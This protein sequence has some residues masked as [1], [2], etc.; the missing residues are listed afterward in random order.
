MDSLTSGQLRTACS[1]C[2]L[3]E[4][5]WQHG[6]TPIDLEQLHGLVRHAENLP[7][8]SHLFQVG[9]KFTA[10]YAVRTGCVKSYTT[11]ASGEEQV[12]GFHMTGDLLG[13]DAIYPEQHRCNAAIVQTCSVCVLP[14]QELMNLAVRLPS[15]QTSLMHLMSREFS[16]NLLFPDGAPAEQRMSAFLLDLSRRQ[17]RQGRPPYELDLAMSR[18]EIASYLGF[19]VETASRL[20]TKMQKEGL[21][22]VKRRLIYLMDMEALTQIARHA[23]SNGPTKH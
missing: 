3:N 6:L 16:I 12:H 20:L 7:I 15:L 13:F 5:C 17:E 19:T 22:K 2:T 18:Q 1:T 21:I 23:S 4:L 8:G 14:Y 9:D 11:D 10:V